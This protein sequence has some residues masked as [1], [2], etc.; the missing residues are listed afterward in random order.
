M[1]PESGSS[2]PDSGSIVLAGKL[3]YLQLVCNGHRIW[4]PLMLSLSKYERSH[5]M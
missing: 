3:A 2:N 5:R 4:P 1:L